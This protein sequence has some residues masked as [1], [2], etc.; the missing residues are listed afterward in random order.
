MDTLKTILLVCLVIIITGM[1]D[2]F[3]WWSFV[4]PVALLGII[5]RLRNWKVACLTIGFLAGFF[6]WSGSNLYFDIIQNGV[7]LE[8]LGNLLAA[9]KFVVILLSGIIGGLLTALALYTGKLLIA[10]KE[11]ELVL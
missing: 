10:E 5:V 8:K 7:I 3:P 1:I 4:I 2:M 9:P 6:I 11:A